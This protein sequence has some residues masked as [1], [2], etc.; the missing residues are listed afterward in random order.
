MN[1]DYHLQ[2]FSTLKI[3]AIPGQQL[4]LE[5]LFLL[6]ELKKEKKNLHDIG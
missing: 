4:V 1:T 6:Y 2:C 5:E 3:T